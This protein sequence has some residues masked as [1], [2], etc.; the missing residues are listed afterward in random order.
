ML[1][2][3][4]IEISSHQIENPSRQ[5]HPVR[6]ANMN[7]SAHKTDNVILSEQITISK[8]RIIIQRAKERM[9]FISNKK[10]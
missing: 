10:T 5:S 9:M 4:R 7:F 1:T 6:T 2:I 3:L 8:M